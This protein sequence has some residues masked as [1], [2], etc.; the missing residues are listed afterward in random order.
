MNHESYIPSHSTF[1][2]ADCG[3]ECPKTEEHVRWN[4]Q[5]FKRWRESLCVGCSELTEQTQT[6]RSASASEYYQ[7]QKDVL[8]ETRV[9]PTFKYPGK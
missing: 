2:C 3:A 8:E 9:L 6:V 4:P 5:G 1:F 7:Q